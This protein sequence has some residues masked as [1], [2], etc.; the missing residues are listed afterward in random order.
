[1]RASR[2][3]DRGCGH[4]TSGQ[5]EQQDVARDLRCTAATARRGNENRFGGT[6]FALFC[7]SPCWRPLRLLS[8]L[9]DIRRLST[10][11]RPIQVDARTRG[12]GEDD[13]VFVTGGVVL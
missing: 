5:V 13:S 4:A 7:R 8:H 9:E 1:M 11:K 2:Q 6:L 10:I 12:L 3:G